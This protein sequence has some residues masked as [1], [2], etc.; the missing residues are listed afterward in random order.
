VTH[1]VPSG[2]NWKDKALSLWPV[3]I[4]IF[5]PLSVCQRP[6]VLSAHLVMIREPSRENRAGNR[7]N[8]S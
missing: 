5:A 7:V 1:R 2:E 6:T 4:E 3:Y 8:A